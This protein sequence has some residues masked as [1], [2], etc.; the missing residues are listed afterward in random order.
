M[1]RSRTTYFLTLLSLVI[2]IDVIICQD[3]DLLSD[4]I[5]RINSQFF[6]QAEK[7]LKVTPSLKTNFCTGGVSPSSI[8]KMKY[9]NLFNAGPCS[10]VVLI[11]GILGSK[12]VAE[13]D[14]QVLKKESPLIFKNCGWTSCGSGKTSPQ[15]E[16]DIWVPTL[17]SI[18]GILYDSDKTKLKC[19]DYIFSLRQTDKKR[20]NGL[21]V[22]EDPPGVKV[23]VYG[24]TPKTKKTSECGDNAIRDLSPV[25]KMFKFGSRYFA[26]YIDI[27]KKAG[28]VGGLTMQSA[29]FDWRKY[30]QD[31]KLAKNLEGYVDDLY[32]LSGGKK[33][34][35]VGHSMG[36][37]NVLHVLSNMDQKK[38]DEKVNVW[39]NIAG[40]ILGSTD[41]IKLPL[42]LDSGLDSLKKFG[43]NLDVETIYS[44]LYKCPSL[45]QL[46]PKTSWEQF[47]GEPWMKE[48]IKRMEKDSS[49]TVYQSK[50]KV[51][52]L[53]PSLDKICQDPYRDRETQK[54]QTGLVSYI[55]LGSIVDSQLDINDLTRVLQEEASDPDSVRRL[56]DVKI[57]DEEFTKLINPGVE[58]AFMYANHLSTGYKL[59]YKNHPREYVKRKQTKNPDAEIKALGDGTVL[60]VSAILPGI[61]WAN[62]F[63]EKKHGA[64]RMSFVEICSKQNR[65]LKLINPKSP[66]GNQ[67]VGVDCQCELDK[68]NDIN[69]FNF[70][71]MDKSDRCTHTGMIDDINLANFVVKSMADPF[72]KGAKG[73]SQGPIGRF[74]KYREADLQEF[75]Q[76][77]K[78]LLRN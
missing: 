78:L 35:I 4:Q 46:M 38:K 25:N 22:F 72:G 60:T 1:N 39:Y 77:C 52:S 19:F 66:N 62:E 34:N 69:P 26:T 12:L 9:L 47:K 56:K 63:E 67:Y 28:Y 53:F 61:K 7:K 54:C 41:A 32:D 59:F 42:G 40:P 48:V 23:S 57:H 50:D 5:K 2:L 27:F 10:P 20:S 74:S 6:K 64:K 30:Y 45:Y 75:V 49:N 17:S 51:M 58:T 71:K 15:T 18:T 21:I 3:H 73:K 24:M 43:V 76:S 16:Y 29:P 8:S 37:F 14:C 68:A 70:D 33:V 44:I 31:N 36:N 65:Q 11:P 55:N 13:I